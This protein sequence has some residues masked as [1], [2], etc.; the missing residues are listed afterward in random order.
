MKS[1]KNDVH[2]GQVEDEAGKEVLEVY[3]VVHHD[4][5]GGGDNNHAVFN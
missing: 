2:N 3:V 5:D 4:D 1:F